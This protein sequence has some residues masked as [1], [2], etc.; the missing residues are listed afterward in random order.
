MANLKAFCY[1]TT[2]SISK[3]VD[4]C[5]GLCPLEI[6]HWRHR[7]ARLTGAVKKFKTT[8]DPCP[9]RLGGSLALPINTDA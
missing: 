1:Q 7:K 6:G 5:T 9:I 4:H 2:I 8:R 3:V